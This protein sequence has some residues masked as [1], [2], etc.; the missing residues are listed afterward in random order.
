MILVTGAT[1]FIGKGLTAKL[2]KKGYQVKVLTRNP[3]LA[4]RL[5]PN[6]VVTEGNLSD[7]N[8]VK[9]AMKDVSKVVHLAGLVDYKDRKR[10]FEINCRCTQNLL[11]C[12]KHVDKFVYSSSVTVYGN[13]EGKADYKTEPHPSGPYGESKVMA[14]NLVRDSG[15]NSA[16]LRIAAVYGEDSPWFDYFLKV[17]SLGIPYPRT[18][19]KTQLVHLSDAVQGIALSVEKG[20]GTF[21]IADEKP[22]KFAYIAEKIAHL[23]GKRY[24]TVPPWM[25]TI[26]AKLLGMDELIIESIEN[27]VFDIARSEDALGFKPRADINSELKRMVDWYLKNR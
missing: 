13:V 2:L 14:E 21:I 19:N 10:L 6:A 16:I 15:I 26:P 25:L 22:V 11:E 4:K 5:F 9:S 12:C 3:E 7:K 20:K 24:W 8:S 1:G 27:R 18:E 23:L 17:M